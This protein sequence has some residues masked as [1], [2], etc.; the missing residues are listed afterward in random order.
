MSGY[1]QY[2]TA[3]FFQS[4]AL[5]MFL[6]LCYDILRI[7]REVFRCRPGCGDLLFWIAAGIFSFTRIYTNNQGSLRA[8]LFLGIF[9]G[10]W[11]YHVTISTFL[12]KF[13]VRLLEIPAGAVKKLRKVLLFWTGRC[14]I[15]ICGFARRIAARRTDSGRTRGSKREKVS[16]TVT[17]KQNSK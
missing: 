17:E 10:M 15:Y 13:F 16:K 1:M 7:F 9:L 4:A 2:E 5:G 8:F 12:V 14:N 6:L 3:L 11:L